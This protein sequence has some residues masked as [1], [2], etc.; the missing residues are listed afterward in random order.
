MIIV[1]VLAPTDLGVYAV[2]LT[3]AGLVGAVSGAFET[4]AFPAIRASAPGDAARV[5]AWA[6]RRTVLVTGA[7][8]LA[9]AATAPLVVDRVFGAGFEGAVPVTRILVVGGVLAGIGHVL[10]AGLRGLDRPLLA[11]TA[12][13]ASLT[14]VAILSLVLVPA[15][16]IQGAAVAAVVAPAAMCLSLTLLWRRAGRPGVEARSSDPAPGAAPR[17]PLVDGVTPSTALV[18]TP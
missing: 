10:R 18:V 1:L 13:L 2:A 8:G 15:H 12:D 14:V 11:A 16:G 3:L 17:A 4:V 7:L 6:V 9:V 5:L